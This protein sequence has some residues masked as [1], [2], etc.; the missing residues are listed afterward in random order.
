MITLYVPR[1]WQTQFGSSMRA[2]IIRRSTPR[3]RTRHKA[4]LSDRGEILN[5]QLPVLQLYPLS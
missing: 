4:A 5:A 1:F 2:A 3:L